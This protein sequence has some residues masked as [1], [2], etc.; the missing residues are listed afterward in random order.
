ML[1]AHG[2][3]IDVV[4]KVGWTAL[5]AAAA[6]GHLETAR[7]LNARGADVHLA[8]TSGNTALPWTSI[9]RHPALTDLLIIH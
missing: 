3:A 9:N 7:R 1:V 8:D 6:G 2:A 4:G 5:M